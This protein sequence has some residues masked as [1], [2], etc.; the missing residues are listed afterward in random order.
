MEPIDLRSDTVTRPTPAMRRAMAE[1]AV[2]DDVYG[3]DP[4]VA[5]LEAAVA[6]RLG[7]EGALFFPSGTMANQ[8]SLHLLARPGDVVL[9]ARDCHILRWEAGAASALSGLQIRELGADGSYDADALRAALHPVE[10]HLAPTTVA[11]LENTHNAAGGVVFPFERQEGVAKAAREAGLALHLDGARLFNAA[12]ASGRSA[13]AWAAPFDTVSVCLSKGLGAPV[14][15]V[16]ALDRARREALRHARKRFGGGM[17]QA[18]VIAAAGL[19]ALEHHVERLADDH[20][21]ARRLAEGL[22]AQGYRVEPEPETNIVMFRVPDARSF[23]EGARERRVLI[24]PIDSERFRAVTHLDVTAEDVEEA[25]R[26]LAE[27]APG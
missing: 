14:G 5:R 6:E 15:S 3:E 21:K 24:N 8:A 18:G 27:I 23:L 22:R 17:R 20:A 1:A 19:H 10:Q 26:R 13:A 25:L 16:V 2:G 11:A 7:K 9:A 4:T 12:V